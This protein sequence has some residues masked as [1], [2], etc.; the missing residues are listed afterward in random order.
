MTKIVYNAC[1]GGFG[2][3][4]KAWR[5]YLDRKGIKYRIE[6]SEFSSLGDLYY[7]EGTDEWLY[8]RDVDR[9]DPVLVAV[10]EE[11]GEKANGMCAS[12]RIDELPE[13]TLYRIDEYDGNESVVT[14]D[15]YDWS[16]A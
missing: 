12:L 15:G 2:L 5:L 11:L 16:V 14:Q 3:S 13:G 6:P 8:D 9:A 7:E 1:Y 10:V 4:D